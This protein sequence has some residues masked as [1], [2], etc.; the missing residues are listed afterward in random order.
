MGCGSSKSPDTKPLWDECNKNDASVQVV[1]DL[2]ARGANVNFKNKY[3]VHSEYVFLKKE[4][5]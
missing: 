1:E 2:I 4:M 3:R 5:H